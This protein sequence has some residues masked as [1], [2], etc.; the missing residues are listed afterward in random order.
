MVIIIAS[1]VIVSFLLGNIVNYLVKMLPKED[2]E[3]KLKDILKSAYSYTRGTKLYFI[4][5]L[6]ILSMILKVYGVTLLFFLYGYIALILLVIA[7]IDYKTTYVYTIVVILGGIV[8]I[9]L[10]IY[11]LAIGTLTFNDLLIALGVLL[12]L[13]ILAKFSSVVALGDVEVYAMIA[14]TMGL[15]LFIRVLV[16]SV[17]VGSV[18]GV[19]LFA[20][21]INSVIVRVVNGGTVSGLQGV[22]NAMNVEVKK[23]VTAFTPSIFVAYMLVVLFNNVITDALTF[24][25]QI[26]ANI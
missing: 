16:L 10:S 14:L 26:Y 1:L 23:S 11:R 25:F 6:A 2:E 20:R 9:G 3:I 18:Y 22:I 5:T 17:I 4:L 19:I 13:Y 8:G 15:G 7:I 12:I 24:I 21:R